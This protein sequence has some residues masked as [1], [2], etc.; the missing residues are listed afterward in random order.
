MT[1]ISALAA[2]VAG[3]TDEFAFIRGE[4]AIG[5]QRLPYYS[6]ALTVRD[7]V[8]YLKL[9]RDLV[10]DVNS[11]VMFDELFQRELAKERAEG[12]I[13]DYLKR[14]DRLKFFNS[15]TV[16]LLP[17]RAG[18][19][20]VPLPAFE[21]APAPET[22][23]F[24]TGAVQGV[25]FRELE[26]QPMGF[27]R[28]NPST[29]WPVVVDGQHR[30]AALKSLYDD[31]AWRAHVSPDSTRVPVLILVLDDAFG[32]NGV[33]DQGTVLTGSRAIFTDLNKYAVKISRAREYLL[34][35]NDLMAVAT[36]RIMGDRLRVDD[37]GPDTGR[38]PLALVDWYSNS[39]KF[40]TGYHLTS[41]VTLHDLV[42]TMIDRNTPRATDYDALRTWLEE[43]DGRLGLTQ[44]EAIDLHA[45]L[46]QL[47]TKEDAEQPFGLRDAEIRRIADAFA[48]DLG[49]LIIRTL[50]EFEPYAAL[51]NAYTEAGLLGSRGEIWLGHDPAGRV[52]FEDYTGENP[53]EIADPI[54]R[55][56]KGGLK[57]W[58][59]RMVWLRRWWWWLVLGW[60][61]VSAR[62][63][64]GVR[65]GGCRGCRSG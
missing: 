19:R 65:V 42:E 48:I 3:F 33:S 25:E 6:T 11:P 5:T 36:R 56:I 23:G 34:D 50:Q 60:I 14:D 41:I 53:A 32:Y 47:R 1:D 37:S 35:D 44:H 38:I 58:L 2:P 45:L 30:F 15:F 59:H 26:G 52:S 16:L 63:S 18:D 27:I 8:T 21:P 61:C 9:A 46:A 43:L 20:P 29:I 64:S 54:R 51:I 17:V 12:P 28:W 49:Q 24:R 4:Y 40:D 22:P 31:E 39:A 57:R 55:E 10:F 13:A 62:S 7:C